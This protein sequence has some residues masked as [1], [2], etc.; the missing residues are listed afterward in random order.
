MIKKL[1]LQ[2]ALTSLKMF[3]EII[4]QKGIPWI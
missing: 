3:K 4:N 1:I 2:I